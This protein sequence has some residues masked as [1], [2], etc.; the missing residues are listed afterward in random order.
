[1]SHEE[2]LSLVA[3]CDRLFETDR[4][5]MA[6]ARLLVLITTPARR[7]ELLALKVGDP[8]LDSQ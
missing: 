7:N 4:P 3:G 8:D 6:R 1:V 5:G 2:L